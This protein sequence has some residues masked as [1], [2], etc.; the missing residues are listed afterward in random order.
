[1]S[2]RLVTFWTVMTLLCDCHTWG[3]GTLRVLKWIFF[4]AFVYLHSC[5]MEMFAFSNKLLHRYTW[6]YITTML[7]LSLKQDYILIHITL[8]LDRWYG[9]V[10]VGLSDLP[11]SLVWLTCSIVFFS[12]VI[13]LYL[14]MTTYVI[15]FVSICQPIRIYIQIY[16]AFSIFGTLVP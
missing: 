11:L 7:V 4:F 3:W 13:C 2:F 6:Q 16:F 14:N 10:K 8:W 9:Y 5:S 15:I 12:C 1:M